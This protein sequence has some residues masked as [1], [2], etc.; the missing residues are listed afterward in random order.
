MTLEKFGII[1]RHI[2]VFKLQKY[3][4]NTGFFMSYLRSS[5]NGGR[6]D[7]HRDFKGIIQSA[8]L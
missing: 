1:Y 7:P 2:L 3:S 4:K 5:G 8:R 6:Y